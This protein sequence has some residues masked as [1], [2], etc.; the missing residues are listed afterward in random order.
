MEKLSKTDLVALLEEFIDDGDKNSPPYFAGRKKVLSDIEDACAQSWERHIAKG[1][2]RKAAT[3]VIYGA[4]GA[5][6]T[7]TLNYLRDCWEGKPES[8]AT[9]DKNGAVRPQ[10]VP[11][12]YLL[13]A[14]SSLDDPNT[15]C[16]E[17][18][19]LL[20]PGVGDTLLDAASST[21]RIGT[22]VKFVVAEAKGE[23][24]T[25]THSPV[26]AA[27]LATVLKAVPP[28]QWTR[29]LVIA[30][31]ETQNLPQTRDC[32]TGKLFQELH[33]GQYDA[34]ITLV[35]GGLSDSIRRA[36]E[37]GLTR[38]SRHCVHSLDR[39][40]AEEVAELKQGF[41]EK[42]EL[43]IGSRE[44]EFD[45]MLAACDG[46]PSHLTNGLYAFC[47]VFLDRD[48][49]ISRVDFAEVERISTAERNQ[50]Y[51]YRMST[52]MRNTDLLLQDVMRHM[53]G[54]R[55]RREVIAIIKH[56]HQLHADDALSGARLPDG[57]SANDY[58]EELTH[59]G[60]LQE[61]DDGMV[62]CP[63]PSFRQFILNT[64]P[65]PRNLA[66]S[67]DKPEAGRSYRGVPEPSPKASSTTLH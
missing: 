2:Q 19:N 65:A 18:A 25:T 53:S 14:R 64:W 67:H 8:Y 7:S 20:A 51:A 60:A 24:E 12:V 52:A 43:D 21:Q 15:F 55:T 9:P 66:L 33:A 17:L 42:F 47:N 45:A 38:L 26:P 13:E 35:L 50:Y 1:R 30:V 63:I 32:F 48:C 39:F 36:G 11:L 31:D 3:R 40:D 61:R 62:E 23:T 58:F 16:E 22:G 57:M 5:G 37:L 29:P 4:P 34:P 59:H 44:A 49:D 27:S 10:P 41:C 56:Q 46:W 28:E 54:R 6:K